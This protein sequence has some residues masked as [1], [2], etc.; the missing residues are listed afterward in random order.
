M[1]HILCIYYLF[2]FPDL[3]FFNSRICLLVNMFEFVMDL[4]RVKFPSVFIFW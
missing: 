4:L 3:E 1:E 2:F